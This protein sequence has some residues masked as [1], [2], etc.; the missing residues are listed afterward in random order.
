MKLSNEVLDRLV[1]LLIYSGLLLV[2][3]GVFLARS[4]A[5]VGWVIAT[6]GAL[7]AAAGALLLWVRSRRRP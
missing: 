2:G 4:D 1:W 7:D 5:V 3:L 6:A